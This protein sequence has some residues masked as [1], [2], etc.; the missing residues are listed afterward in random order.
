MRDRLAFHPLGPGNGIRC[1]H[2]VGPGAALEHALLGLE[3]GRRHPVDGHEAP[4]R[5]IERAQ[6]FLHPRVQAQVDQEWVDG[7]VEELNQN[8]CQCQCQV[9]VEKLNQCQCHSQANQLQENQETGEIHLDRQYHTVMRKKHHTFI[10][11]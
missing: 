9:Q 2:G 10:A 5:V 8:Q 4:V 7:Q 1:R 6:R 3:A 11:I